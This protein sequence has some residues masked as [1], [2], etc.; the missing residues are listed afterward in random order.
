MHL[1]SDKLIKGYNTMGN[2]VLDKVIAVESLLKEYM[3]NHSELL[4]TVF[5]LTQVIQAISNEVKQ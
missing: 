2:D 4:N 3:G 1:R 5:E